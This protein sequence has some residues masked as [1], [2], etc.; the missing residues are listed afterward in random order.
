MCKVG[1]AVNITQKDKQ[2]WLMCCSYQFLMQL[3]SVFHKCKLYVFIC[4]SM[5][6]HLYIVYILYCIDLY[7]TYMCIYIIFLLS[8]F[9]CGQHVR[10]SSCSCTMIRKSVFVQRRLGI[11]FSFLTTPQPPIKSC[12]KTAMF[13][14]LALGLEF[15]LYN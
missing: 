13:I 5:Y 7:Y 11:C 9:L 1:I 6:I 8:P 14:G 15:V 12:K 10:I 2:V 3:L 4:I